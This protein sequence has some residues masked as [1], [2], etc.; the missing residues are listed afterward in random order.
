M[1]HDRDLRAVGKR[2]VGG[3][4][5]GIDQLREL[6]G[7]S[8]DRIDHCELAVEGDLVRADLDVGR[9]TVDRHAPD[10]VIQRHTG[11]A[12]HAGVGRLRVDVA[13]AARPRHH[14]RRIFERAASGDDGKG[15]V[16]R[17]ADRE[18]AAQGVDL[19]RQRGRELGQRIDDDRIDGF[20]VD[21]G[22]RGR[23]VVERDGP[24]LA[25]LRATAQGRRGAGRRRHAGR[26]GQR[27]GGR[28]QQYLE[29]RREGGTGPAD[30]HQGR[31][32]RRRNDVTVAGVDRAGQGKRDFRRRIHHDG[33]TARRQG[34][35]NRYCV[36]GGRVDLQA[37][38]VANDRIAAQVDGDGL[39]GRLRGDHTGRGRR[40][41]DHG[42]TGE[43]GAGALGDIQGR[44]A[45]EGGEAVRRTGI[46]RRGQGA[47]DLVQGRRD[48]VHGHAGLR[49]V[50][51]DDPAV[52][53]DRRAGQPERGGGGGLPCGGR[54]ARRQHGHGSREQGAV[55][56]GKTGP[57]GGDGKAR[58]DRIGRVVQRLLQA[59]GDLRQRVTGQR[60]ITHGGDGGGTRCIRT[61]RDG[62]HPFPAG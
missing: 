6:R 49:A 43:R 54:I 57:A 28:G 13:D 21:H 17:S 24:G 39:T 59:R 50:D 44:S 55:G 53:G 46:D 34:S 27:V 23:R 61:H 51:A 45:E 22:D 8:R 31:A 33:R 4:E 58:P 62:E 30:Q 36:D 16:G 48:R 42:G 41:S 32:D 9:I 7:D 19:E 38:G 47:A 10:G 15:I 12:E 37:P 11:Q 1:P 60:R 56:Q 26:S 14:R 52:A 5:V 3:A 20:A 40:Q 35:A 2:A 29:V 25:G 18:E